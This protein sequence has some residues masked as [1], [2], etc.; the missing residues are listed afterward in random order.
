[1]VKICIDQDRCK[2]CRLCIIACPKGIITMGKHHNSTGY[3]PAAKVEEKERDCI[4]C[5]RCYQM[6]PEVAIE[7]WKE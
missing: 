7:I 2:G 3:Y 1:M 5:G 4:T 6:C